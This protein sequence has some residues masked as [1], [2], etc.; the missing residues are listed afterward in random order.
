MTGCRKIGRRSEGSVA[1]ETLELGVTMA[2]FHSSGVN[3]IYY[4]IIV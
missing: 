1:F 2:I 3:L 4:C